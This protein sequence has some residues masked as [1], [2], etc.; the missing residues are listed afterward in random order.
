MW[1]FLLSYAQ[2]VRNARSHRL[3]PSRAPSIR[4]H[5]ERYIEYATTPR[6]PAI[7]F[8]FPSS[9]DPNIQASRAPRCNEGKKVTKRKVRENRRRSTRLQ[10]STKNPLPP[11][12]EPEAR[13]LNPVR[14]NSISEF[15]KQG[16]PDGTF[17]KKR[18]PWVRSSCAR[19]SYSSRKVF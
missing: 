17:F 9:R 10:R 2:S 18:L 8:K 14:P 16:V 3:S 6:F 7:D 4:T 12:P 13:S 15:P 19:Q 5:A 11:S 1:V